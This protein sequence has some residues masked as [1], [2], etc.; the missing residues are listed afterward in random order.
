MLH[1]NAQYRTRCSNTLF[2]TGGC[3]SPRRI[4]VHITRRHSLVITQPPLPVISGTR[5]TATT[6]CLACTAL[7]GQDAVVFQ[8]SGYQ[9]C[10][11][12]HRPLQAGTGKGG[13]AMCDTWVALP[14]MTTTQSVIFAKN[15]D[16]PIFDCQPL[17]A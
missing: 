16:R 4:P 10:V 11:A 7:H 12:Q 6:I 3:Q 2:V 17:V 9:R 15:S 5:Y 1:C 8:L 14:D 13:L